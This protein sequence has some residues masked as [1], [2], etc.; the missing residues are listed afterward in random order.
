[1]H[2][3]IQERRGRRALNSRPAK[4]HSET[5]SD[6]ETKTQSKA[7]VF[8]AYNQEGRSLFGSQNERRENKTPE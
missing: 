2:I 1:M 5:A 4:L 7:S 8:C 3:Y 6:K